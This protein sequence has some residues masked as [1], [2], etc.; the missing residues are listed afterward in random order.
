MSLPIPW[1]EIPKAEELGGGELPSSTTSPKFQICKALVLDS[2]RV[3]NFG[4]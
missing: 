3:L 4:I 2:M 1:P